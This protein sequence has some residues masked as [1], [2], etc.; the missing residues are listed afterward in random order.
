MHLNG[1]KG[2]P[3]LYPNDKF[4]CPRGKIN[5]AYQFHPFAQTL[6]RTLF[7][8]Q[9]WPP[10]P[11]RK[12]AFSKDPQ[13]RGDPGTFIMTLSTD[14]REEAVNQWREE[15]NKG[16]KLKWKFWWVAGEGGGRAKQV[17]SIQ[18]KA[19]QEGWAGCQIRQAQETHFGETLTLPLLSLG[20]P[21]NIT[22][23]LSICIV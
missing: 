4:H 23:S 2:N 22:L 3:G 8:L 11:W 15:S 17:G 13:P 6:S 10:K 20:G 14:P 7:L 1:K 19:A 9:G 12:V 16:S 5:Q 21:V 18:A